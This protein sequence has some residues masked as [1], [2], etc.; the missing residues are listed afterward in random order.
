[1]IKIKLSE[2]KFLIIISSFLLLSIAGYVYFKNITIESAKSHL[3]SVQE[4]LNNEIKDYFNNNIENFTKVIVEQKQIF[5]YLNDLK[6]TSLNSPEYLKKKN[7]LINEFKKTNSLEQYKDIIFITPEGNLIFSAKNNI[8]TGINVNEKIDEYQIISQLINL[9]QTLLT[10]IIS[11][12]GPIG[13]KDKSENSLFISFPCLF[14]DHVIGMLAIKIDAETIYKII[15]KY[16]NNLGNTGDIFISKRSNN[17]ALIIFNTR[18]NPNY[19]FKFYKTLSIKSPVTLSVLGDVVGSDIMFVND[20]LVLN[21]RGYLIDSSWSIAVEQDLSEVLFVPNIIKTILFILILIYIF[22][23]II[24][25]NTRKIIILNSFK[26]YLKSIISDSALILLAALAIL[27][28]YLIREYKK[29]SS[30]F[31]DQQINSTA[32]DVKSVG[33][34]L[35]ENLDSIKFFNHSICLDLNNQKFNEKELKDYLSKKLSGN[36]NI[37]GIYVA[38]GNEK[39]PYYIYS[40]NQ[41]DKISTGKTEISSKNINQIKWYDF[42]LKNKPEWIGPFIEKESKDLSIIYTEPFFSK[43]NPNTPIGTVA[44]VYPFSNIKKVIAYLGPQK[45]EISLILSEDDRLIYHYNEE[46]V[47]GNLSFD[48]IVKITKKD[49]LLKIR[50]RVK[51][52]SSGIEKFIDENNHTI[53]AFFE[54]TPLTKWVF[55]TFYSDTELFQYVELDQTFNFLSNLSILILIVLMLIILI[56]GFL[57]IKPYNLQIKTMAKYSILYSLVLLSGTIYIYLLTYKNSYF[58]MQQSAI[59]NE[60][61]VQRALEKIITPTTIL[62]PTGIYANFIDISDSNNCSF[63]ASI[64]QKYPKLDLKPQITLQNASSNL[65]IKEM[66]Q[67]KEKDY[68]NIAFQINGTVFQRSSFFF[69]PFDKQKIEIDLEY[70]FVKDDVILTPFIDS[71][72]NLAP[73][74]KIGINKELL[75]KYDIDKTFFSFK[76]IPTSTNYG[77]HKNIITHNILTYNIMA[78]RNPMDAFILVILPLL[79]IILAMFLLQILSMN[80]ITLNMISTI[81]IY[82]ALLFPT[83]LL[84]QSLR[85]KLGVSGVVYIEYLLFVIYLLMVLLCIDIST[86]EKTK[87]FEHLKITIFWPFILTVMFTVTLISYYIV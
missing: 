70:P 85:S 56:S 28:G 67:N 22:W 1:M 23:I 48:D 41:N 19:A 36:K 75:E 6:S 8:P 61:D 62:I 74:Q 82:I 35:S 31:D 63:F 72:K 51:E 26:K 25:F 21:A 81:S 39:P 38:Y 5:K 69:Y 37:T 71:Y 7:D 80:A 79:V 76:S 40:L 2:L 77:I 43:D 14:E 20:K 24:I 55:I 52:E 16:Y 54:V 50:S 13:P 32:V 27:L 33:S 17:Q 66:Y 44:V 11:E 47:L 68:L 3:N 60:I 34:I 42:K 59:T 78:S 65:N 53:Y 58:A 73:E 87:L 45:E 57:V 9:T 4:K 83:I 86:G 64:W 18:F 46:Y 49:V 84:H 12:F 15:S 29:E 30:Y 10:P